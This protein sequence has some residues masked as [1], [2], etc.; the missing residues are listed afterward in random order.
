MEKNT[1]R[2][3]KQSRYQEDFEHL[4]RVSL[5]GN[6]DFEC[7]KLLAMLSRRMKFTAGD[8]LMVQ[9]EDDGNAYLILDGSL[10]AILDTGDS[11]CTMQ[12]FGVGD[13][14]GGCALL[15]RMTRLFSLQA[16]DKTTVLFL[17]RDQVKKTL[18]RFPESI[19]KITANLVG[20]LTKWDQQALDSRSTEQTSSCNIGISLR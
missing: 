18:S 20:E 19:A 15:G 14:I 5:L 2:I 12:K 10:E 8:Q 7:L 3:H 6:I 11:R 1:E 13:F 9:G 17:N 4:R 16:Q